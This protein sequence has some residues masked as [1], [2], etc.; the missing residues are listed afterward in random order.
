MKSSITVTFWGR[1]ELAVFL[2]EFFILQFVACPTGIPQILSE[3][4]K[5]PS[6]LVP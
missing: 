3:L 5:G 1:V 2:Q 6:P 4:R